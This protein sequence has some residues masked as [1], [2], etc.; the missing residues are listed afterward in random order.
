MSAIERAAE[1][2]RRRGAARTGAAIE[3]MV[4]DVQVSVS[5][6]GVTIEGRG[7]RRR[8]LGDMRTRWL[9]EWLK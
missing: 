5:E 9:G 6:A 2:A 3:A 1:R 8:W 7:L 4:P